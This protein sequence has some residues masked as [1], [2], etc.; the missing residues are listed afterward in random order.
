MLVYLLLAIVSSVLL[1]LGLLMMKS[2]AEVLPAARGSG[3]VRGVIAWIGDPIW[4]GGLGVQTLGYAL[5]VIAIAGAPISMIA[6]MMQGGIGL[7]VLL[8][9]V[10]LGERAQ[11]REWAGIGAIIA[12]MVLLSLSLSAGEQQGP[13][14]VPALL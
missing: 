5:Y 1:A 12:G 8:S 4:L 3:I 10:F 14:D 11:A 9:A 6:V 2:R 13:L 7:F